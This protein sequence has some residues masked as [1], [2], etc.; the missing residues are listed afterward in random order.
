MTVCVEN[1]KVTRVRA[2]EFLMTLALVIPFI[3]GC[4]GHFG[5]SKNEAIL[6][7]ESLIWTR[8]DSTIAILEGLDTVFLTENDKMIS[9]SHQLFLY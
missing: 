1:K 8:P 6:T 3:I 7:A 5:T 4:H 9:I 2:G